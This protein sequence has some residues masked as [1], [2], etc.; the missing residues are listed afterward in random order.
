MKAVFLAAAL[1]VLFPG[2][3]QAE[4]G[5]QTDGLT[6]LKKVA[7]AAH[8]LNYSGTYIYQAG[9]R[10]ETSR[11]THVRD[12]AGEHEKLE[13]LDGNPREIIRN[14]NEVICFKPEAADS[15]V[16]EKRRTEKSFPAM[17]P[18]QLGAIAENYRIVVGEQDRA[19]G[20]T[21]QV[22]MLEP[23]DQ[24]R[25]RLKLWVDP[26][27][28]LLLKA[29][30]LNE[31]NDVVAQFAFTQVSIGGQ[32]DKGM[33]KPKLSGKKVVLSTEPVPRV[34]L[35]SDE[36]GWSV[37]QLPAGF[38]QVTMTRRTMPGK[39]S[40]VRH[41]VFSDGLAT[42]SVFIE[43]LAAGTKPMQGAGRQGVINVYTRLVSDHQI[44]V[45]GE[46]PAVT[47]MQVANSVTKN[48]ETR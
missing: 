1:L 30:T 11:I 19:A 9:D 4:G 3:S 29:T 45:L 33:L 22:I 38:G 47:V 5:S 16:V 25:Y 44:T 36:A 14:N 48:Q 27:S 10:V 31:K 7:T 32:I 15:I 34:E 18:P 23:K 41:L 39:G 43:P 13:A 28:G 12:D 46:V 2:A 20:Q 21:C 42:I 26:T 35:L 6:W 8:Q 24:F 17:L 40:M 37:R